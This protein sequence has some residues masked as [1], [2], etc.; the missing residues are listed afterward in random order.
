MCADN[1]ATG[2]GGALVDGHPTA[3]DVHAHAMPWRLLEWLEQR[4]LADMSRAEAGI[5]VLDPS[6]HTVQKLYN[7]FLSQRLAFPALPAPAEVVAE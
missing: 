6:V 4:D 5:V 3:V 2:D 7:Y 1:H